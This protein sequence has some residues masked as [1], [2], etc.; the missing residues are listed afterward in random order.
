MVHTYL[1]HLEIT[2]LREF[3][4][5]YVAVERLL[6]RV[7]SVVFLQQILEDESLSAD[8]ATIPSFVF[9][10]DVAVISLTSISTQSPS[11]VARI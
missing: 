10:H 1:V 5:A 9:A 2:L 8:V 4:T 11:C 3:F 6:T 7:R